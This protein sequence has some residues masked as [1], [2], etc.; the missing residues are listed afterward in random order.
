MNHESILADFGQFGHK[1]GMAVHS[2][3]DIGMFKAI[4]SVPKRKSAKALDKFCL[5]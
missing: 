2:S 4:S 5:R 3:L 1:Q